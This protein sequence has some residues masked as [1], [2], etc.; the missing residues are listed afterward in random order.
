MFTVGLA[1]SA[2]RGFLLDDRG[3]GVGGLTQGLVD[4]RHDG[5]QDKDGYQGHFAVGFKEVV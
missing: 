3:F 2:A 5:H 1:P 4:V